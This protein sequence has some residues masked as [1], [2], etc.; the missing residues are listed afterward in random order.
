MRI[1]WYLALLVLAACDQSPVS[2]NDGGDAGGLPDGGNSDSGSDSGWNSGGPDGGVL[3][4][5]D[6][7]FANSNSSAP[8]QACGTLILSRC[9]YWADCGLIGTDPESRTR[10]ATSLYI[11]WCGPNTW[12]S[13]VAQGTLGFEPLLLQA[14]AD[15]FLSTSC[16]NYASEPSACGATFLVPK[17]GL[18]HACFSGYPDCADGLTC[19]GLT[20]PYRCQPPATADSYNPVCTSDLDCDSGLACILAPR[21]I[22]GMCGVLPS[23]GESCLQTYRCAA[24]SW[25]NPEGTCAPRGI[26]GQP[27]ASSLACALDAYCSVL[28]S[29]CQPMGVAQGSSCTA[30]D[31]CRQPLRCDED[32]RRCVIEAQEGEPCT[33]AFSCEEHLTC[34]AATGTCQ[35]RR[36]MGAP[37]QYEYDCTLDATCGADRTCVVRP[38]YGEDCSTT[39]S[40]FGALCGPGIVSPSAPRYCVLPIRSGGTCL[41]DYDC[42]SG[43]CNGNTCVATCTP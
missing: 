15:A 29:T 14:C 5:I 19:R 10:C 23:A 4:W 36:P 21:A 16:T 2:S 24:D 6:A 33:S 40:C 20:C 37:C 27:C 42:A 25:C 31:G 26:P 38:R 35:K 34:D 32:K 7:G 9:K 3:P 30:S 43:V 1:R 8:L 12:P 41:F 28:T 13:H 39:P 22:S 17:A 11:S 18:N